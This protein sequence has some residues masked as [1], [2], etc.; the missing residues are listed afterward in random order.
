MSLKLARHSISSNGF[1]ATSRRGSRE[2]SRLISR[3]L[4]LRLLLPDNHD[5]FGVQQ[6]RGLYVADQGEDHPAFLLKN[7]KSCKNSLVT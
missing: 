1:P 7:G 6:W 5:V 2:P 4:G 3:N